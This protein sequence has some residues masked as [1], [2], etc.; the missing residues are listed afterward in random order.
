MPS[1]SSQFITFQLSSDAVQ[2]ELPT[3]SLMEMYV[4]ERNEA[5]INKVE[6]SL[7]LNV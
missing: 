6:L 7:Y 4:S 5:E 1:T 3:A 2:P